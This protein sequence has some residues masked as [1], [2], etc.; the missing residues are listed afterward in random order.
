MLLQKWSTPTTITKVQNAGKKRVAINWNDRCQQLFDDMKCLCTM[1]PIFVYANFTKPFK[2]HTDTCRFGLGTVP[3]QT[4]DDRTDAI[5]AYVSRNLKKGETYYPTHKLEFLTLKW[6]LVEKLHEYL[7]RLTFD[8]YTNN[9]SL[10]YILMMAK[11]DDVT[12]C[13]VVSLVNY[14]FQLYYG[15]VKTNID[16]DALSRVP[17][18][19]YVP[20]VSGIHHWVNAVVVW[21]MQ[22]ATLDGPM[23]SIE[24]YSCDV[25]ILDLVGDSPQI[26][27][28]T[29]D[30]CHQAQWVDPVLGLMI[31]R[32]QDRTLGQC[33]FKLTGP[34]ELLQFLWECNQVKLR[35]SILYRK[36]LQKKPRRPYFNWSSQ[37]HIGRPLWEGATM[38]SATWVSK[39]CLTWSMTISFGLKWLNR[40]RNISRSATSVSSSRWSNRGLPWRISWPHIP[41]C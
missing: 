40:K 37:P 13:W 21:A 33:P 24:A 1:A 26:V 10:T 2:L 11:L 41:R 36:T 31:L 39:E 32:M 19:R 25:C 4:H 15:A 9:N 6:A 14:N 18:P 16:V 23:S 20:K 8:I 29:T 5:I 34:P 22:K 7:Y 3:Y 35:Q 28:M 27:C 17:W 30:N 12:H 38:R